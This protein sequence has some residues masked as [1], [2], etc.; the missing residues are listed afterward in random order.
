MKKVIF[1]KNALL[2]T[3]TA[4]I[5]RLAGIIFKVW[6]SSQLGSEGVGLYQLTLSLYIFIS[7]FA[8]GGICTAVTR[9]CA[10]RLALGDSR[11]SYSALK[12]GILLS[13]L[14]SAV[15][16]FLLFSSADFFAKN[17]LCDPR[18]A[19]S[20]RV[21]A[22]SL[23][24]TA[25]CSCLRG[26]FFARSKTL[27]PSL[28]QILEQAVRIFI[29]VFLLGY[30]SGYSLST[31]CA[32]AF[33]GDAAAEALALFILYLSYLSD[34]RRLG[35]F[36]GKTV[37]TREI[38][39]IATPITLTRYLNSGLRAAENI[40]APRALS[41][42]SPANALSQFGLIKGMALP[43]LFFP[44]SFLT[45]ISTLLIPEMSSAAKIGEKWRIR[46]A[47][48]RAIS[49]TFLASFIIAALFFA[50]SDSFGLLIYKSREVG[51]LLRFLAPL[52]PLMYIDS[53]CDG[54]LKG[55]D[56]QR[57]L[58]FVTVSDSALR[59]ILVYPVV[60]RFG[61][62]GFLWIMVGS[63]IYSAT[64]RLF[65]TLKCA[66]VPL[67][68]YQWLLK[69]F[70]CSLLSVG[71]VKFIILKLNLPLLAETVVICLLS[72]GVYALLM[73][74]SIKEELK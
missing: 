42:L 5:L 23:P 26:Y 24:F 14:I 16:L 19:A 48:N 39:R 25:V 4:L 45:A 18:A 60:S 43:L 68:F 8:G 10:E 63:N 3:A 66:D 35:F 31:A 67:Q 32:I 53:L 15:S 11:G 38:T 62:L 57:F 51:F 12:K 61:I 72:A 56:R 7:A 71:I 37:R 55:L 22:V 52:V 65:S 44:S 17:L 74:R 28:T 27:I 30:F 64:L 2:L 46:Y 34:K 73:R 33:L 47:A 50:L 13:F 58:F 69:P 6:L 21:L 49:L 40:L 29:V 20:L 70:V 1:I 9:L 41:V 59:L 54:F 36:G